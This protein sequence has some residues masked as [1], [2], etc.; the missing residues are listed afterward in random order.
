M[1]NIGEIEEIEEV[2]PLELPAAE[3]VT[4]QPEPQEVPQREPEEVP[5]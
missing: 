1:G 5:V 4:V 3:P 2:L